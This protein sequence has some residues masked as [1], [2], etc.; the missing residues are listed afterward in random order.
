MYKKLFATAFIFLFSIGLV[1][2]QEA[3]PIPRD[4][5]GNP[6]IMESV[7]LPKAAVKAYQ[8]N[9]GKVMLDESFEGGAIPADWT[10]YNLDG[11]SFDWT[12]YNSS[13]SAHTGNYSARIHYNGSGN[14][15]WLITP[16]LNITAGT[17]D[18]LKFWAK[19]YSTSYPEDFRILVSTT[20]NQV[21][22]FTDVLLDT[23][24]EALGIGTS[25][26][27]LK[28]PLDAYDGQ[29]IY[30]AY[31][32][33]AVNDFYTYL[34][35]FNG[36]EIYL[37]PIPIFSTPAAEIDLNQNYSLIPVG[38]GASEYVYVT[39][40]GGSDLVINGVNTSSPEITTD[41][42]GSL[43][44]PGGM[45][46]SILVTWTPSAAAADTG[47]VEFIH[48]GSTSPDSV[49]FT[50]HS[51]PA[52]SYVI[53]FEADAGYWVLPD[54]YGFQVYGTF[55]TTGVNNHWGSQ[56]NWWS[57][58]WGDSS[59]MISPRL[60]L[61]SGPTDMSFYHKS[62]SSSG[63]DT[64]FVSLTTDGGATW[65]ELDKIVNDNTSFAYVSYD[66]SG[67]AGNDNV[68][69]K[70][71]YHW[72]TG[73]TSGANWYMDDLALPSR[74][75]PVAAQLSATPSAVHFGEVLFGDTAVAG[76]ILSNS[77]QSALN[78][79]SISSDNPEFAVSD[80]PTLI[81][82]FEND[83]IV[84][85]YIPSINGAVS[86]N[87]TVVHDGINGS[88]EPLI[89]P[90]TG[91]GLDNTI[92]IFPWTE[93]F[94]NGGSI[95][96]LW[97]NDPND[98]GEDWDFDTDATYGPDYD[99]TS[100]S[101]YLAYVD[102]SSPNDSPINLITP[103]LDLT[104]M[105]DPMLEFYCW[106]FPEGSDTAYL[107]IDVYDGSTWNLDVVDSIGNT[108]V[109]D[110]LRQQV[111]L[112]SYSSANTKIRFR[113]VETSG[114]QHDI[115]ID[116]VTVKETPTNPVFSMVPDTLAF[117]LIPV[118]QVSGT[119][120][121][122]VTNLG[123]GTLVLDPAAAI[124]G[125]NAS[126]F[127]LMDT[128]SYPVNL[129]TGESTTISVAFAPATAGDL[130]ALLEVYAGGSTYTGVL[131]GSSYQPPVLA[132]PWMETF[133]TD[134]F[135][136]NNWDLNA[137][138]G[139]PEIID[140][141]GVST[142]T[143]DQAMPSP[144]YMLDITGETASNGGYDQVLTGMFDMSA[145]TP[146]YQ[147]SVWAS[148]HDLEDG[149]YVVIDFYGNDDNWHSLD[150]LFGTNAGYGTFLPFSQL[151]YPLPAEAYHSN[152]QFRITASSNMTSS[153]EYF[154]DDLALT[155]M[156]GWANL[157]WPPSTTT[158]VG[159]PTELIFGQIWIDGVTPDSLAPITA[160]VGYGPNGSMPYDSAGVPS[161]DWTWVPA[162]FNV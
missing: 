75:I 150:T 155:R 19:R 38:V 158:T 107:H 64:I 106:S 73:S 37:P 35:D 2:A 7:N 31:H 127:A 30:V 70:W 47:W 139:Q 63:D 59:Y 162:Q 88:R 17:A 122:T 96:L 89:I 57:S 142:S 1:Y 24:L 149:E 14:D 15:D 13:S 36:P 92:A 126:D 42:S 111:P 161:A 110:W 120:D 71:D 98:S 136:M 26:A 44:I 5:A 100:G 39:N 23:T 79:S 20:D 113:V 74:Y 147:F 119:Q 25:Y 69:I 129:N 153:D 32:Y 40:N 49:A 43:T 21:A 102:D 112:A 80:I 11:D 131:T 78:I 95:P 84:V 45:S 66:L 101:G 16:P 76:V 117:G 51:V 10:V 128:N 82:S 105:T 138:N 144:P 125:A 143:F 18:T 137:F 97:I 54:G 12:A 91:I 103:T 123:G 33:D 85:T 154:F 159:N 8:M 67:W 60:D 116:D 146:D 86:G 141:A 130:E 62:A 53:D 99:H 9:R 87:I 41:F 151:S 65:T 83:T 152:L 133:P 6:D 115:A 160:Q 104:S 135:D 94:E 132:T 46:D 124:S 109:Q 61:T 52:G 34:D 140:T 81:N 48:N 108:G 28:V 50:L 68:R 90:V 114:Y 22:S 77:G 156:I 56:G 72:P 3:E 93:D 29:I 145:T 121:F 4:K 157:Q 134:S 148:E 27:E 58:S 55:G 118:G